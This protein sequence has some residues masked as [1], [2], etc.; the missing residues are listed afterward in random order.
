MDIWEPFDLRSQHDEPWF[1]RKEVLHEMLTGIPDIARVGI[2]SCK[3]I[4]Q[5]LDIHILRN[6]P[7]RLF[8]V[9]LVEI[10]INRQPIKVMLLGCREE[11]G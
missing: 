8:E 3:D 5:M 6:D 11:W 9:R 4:E 10:K 1:V 7:S 2:N